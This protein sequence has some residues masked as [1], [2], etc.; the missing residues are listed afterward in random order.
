MKNRFHGHQMIFRASL[1]MSLV[2]GF[3]LLIWV[4]TSWA[5]RGSS[6]RNNVSLAPPTFTSTIYLPLITVPD[7]FNHI[8]AIW[9]HENPPSSHEVSLF[10]HSFELD[11][12]VI[13]PTLSIFADTRYEVWIDGQWIGRGP[14][15]FSDMT[16]EYD[17]YTLSKLPVGEHVI[18]ILAQWAP[19]LRRSNS[20]TPLIMADIR[21]S[22]TAGSIQVAQTSADWKGILSNAWHNDPYPVHAWGALGP[23][24]LL[25][26]RLLP[27]DWMLP[28]FD[29]K[30]WPQVVAKLDPTT[31]IYRPRSIPML[32]Q[33]P[34]SPT[35]LDVGRLS[36][37][38]Q[39][40]HIAPTYETTTIDFNL[41][42]QSEIRL[43]MLTGTTYYPNALIEVNDQTLDWHLA[44]ESRPDV[45][46]TTVTLPAGQHQLNMPG[47]TYVDIPL[48][49]SIFPHLQID[50]PLDQG[51]HAGRRLLLA[52]FESDPAIGITTGGDS[53]DMTLTT[54]PAYVVLDMGRIIHGRVD[55]EVSG[56]SG[57]MLDMGWDERVLSGTVRPLPH[58]GTLH[59]E[60]NQVDSWVLDNSPRTISSIDA[61]VGRYILIA[62]WGDGTLNL[63]NIRIYEERYP[64]KQQGI[65]S[66][67][68]TRLN[69]IWQ[70]GVDTLQLN[71][72]DA[73]AD[74]W[75]ERGQWWGDA[76]AD[77]Q[78]GQAVF[79]DTLLLGRGVFYIAEATK[80][81]RPPAYA[82]NA[83]EELLHDYGL[84]W[85]QSLEDYQTLSGD[86][87]LGQAVYPTLVS[88]MT[89][90]ASR[91]NSEV[92]LL[93]LPRGHWS[94][95]SLIDWLAHFDR[96]GQSSALNAM[97]YGTLLDAATVAEGLGHD[98][99]AQIWRQ[100]ASLV[101]AAI[102]ENLYIPEQGRYTS[103]F[104]EGE[105]QYAS[106]HAQAWTL[107]YDVVPEEN[108]AAVTES[109]L[110]LLSKDPA[111]PN[112]DIYGMG[113]VLRA[114]GKTGRIA[115]GLAL[116]ESHYGRL[117]DL[118]A[119]TWWEGFN[120][121]LAYTG[122]LSHGWG[123]SPT[124]F[125]S[126]YV[127]GV[128]RLG[129]NDWQ[130]KPALRGL[131]TVSGYLPL[132]K[133]TLQVSWQQQP[134]LQDQVSL[135][136][137]AE[138]HGKIILP[139][140]DTTTAISLNNQAIWQQGQPLMVEGTA[141]NQELMLP[142]GHGTYKFDIQ[143]SCSF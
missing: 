107:A 18:A 69:Q 7:R 41:S 100:R 82:P 70:V 121:H 42:Q 59:P 86:K 132:E 101:K 61:R 71:M 11:I 124:T 141:V 137:P 102:N 84:L 16:R 49:V 130:V 24:E 77:N 95:T 72:T 1:I 103:S 26:L 129:P 93:D 116:I 81:G 67:S 80:A 50:L 47:P 139:L 51:R 97:Y 15:R 40:G 123:G 118:E 36:P 79:S 64:V 38:F 20:I 127:L 45:Y 25:D 17:T 91:E 90:F 113:W 5:S 30:A 14:A 105:V 8:S 13:S 28:N 128:K 27:P 98:D 31:V 74:P 133:G 60:W 55:L 106:P 2:I 122:S 136:V 89:Y 83:G 109:L 73:Y 4:Y 85:V 96:F 68:N 19:N 110:D 52:Q 34:F 120:A 117:L 58:P 10:R 126:T 138:S 63:K 78:I 108:V 135:T 125:L 99:Q 48:G 114:L 57:T 94:E 22:T 111:K 134:C 56:Q 21:G 62:A 9:T 23:T 32:T 54:L 115:D 53:F 87:T 75:R 65:F 143:H 119:T 66:S 88:V 76:F 140:L 39:T 44:D 3:A 12:T 6:H 35:V 131:D 142:L 37:G 46:Q 112:V 92:H 33:V 43:E 29:D 104:L